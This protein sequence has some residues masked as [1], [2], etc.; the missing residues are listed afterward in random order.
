MPDPKSFLSHE[1]A[2]KFCFG[3]LGRSMGMLPQK[4]FKIKGPRLA[5]NAF[6]DIS[7]WK[8]R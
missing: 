8:T 1:E 5:K 2:R 4:M 6:P 7:A 3:F